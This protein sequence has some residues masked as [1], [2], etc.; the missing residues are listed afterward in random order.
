MRIGII[1]ASSQVGSSLS[2]YLKLAGVEVICFTRSTYSEIFFDILG[3]RCEGVDLNDKEDLKKKFKGLDA[4]VDFTYPTG[5]I[6]SI[7][8]SIRKNTDRI[9]SSMPINAVYIY[10]SSI[11][12]YGMPPE[13]K[14]IY[15]YL[16]PRSSYAYLKRYAEKVS[17]KI[18]KQFGV[19]VYNFRLGQ[20]HGN[21][22]SVNSSFRKKLL[23][24]DRAYVDGTPDDLTNTI[25]VNS[26]SEAILKCTRGVNKPGIYTLVSNPQWTLK[27]LY[28]YYLEYYNLSTT[29]I[30]QP[31]KKKKSKFIFD[32]F[33]NMLKGYRSFLETNI[34]INFPS[35][36]L[37]IKGSY[38][39]SQTSSLIA[40]WDDKQYIDFN[41]LGKPSLRV[42]ELETSTVEKVKEEEHRFDTYYQ[43]SVLANRK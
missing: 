33:F 34:L 25:F 2:Y 20:V 43:D 22:Q 36:A 35:A 32:Y 11:M 5:Q 9:I 1:G 7:K 42:M 17:K 4:V 24:N 19:R 26:I 21:L 18:G 6:F 12:A 31:S 10:M 13:V 15:D 28:D 38:R 27:E 37:R 3:I 23:Q 41:L 30:Y 40:R 14:Y 16:I 8:S 29:L 39:M